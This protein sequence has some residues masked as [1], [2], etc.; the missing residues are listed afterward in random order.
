MGILPGPNESGG[1][2]TEATSEQCAAPAFRKASVRELMAVRLAPGQ[3]GYPPTMRPNAS[4]G[5][6]CAGYRS[7][8]V[9][10]SSRDAVGRLLVRFVG[11][12]S[13]GHS[14]SRR[15]LARELK[16]A[17]PPAVHP[18]LTWRCRLPSPRETKATKKPSAMPCGKKLDSGPLGDLLTCIMLKCMAFSPRSPALC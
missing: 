10:V 8:E 17:T 6:A 3:V 14:G 12:N 16:W 7:D 1:G 5:F 9:A 11:T 18:L 15:E 13:R 4:L 2:L